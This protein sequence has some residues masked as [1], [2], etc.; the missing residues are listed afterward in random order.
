MGKK[1]DPGV[2]RQLRAAVTA[3]VAKKAGDPVVLDVRKLAD[4]CDYFFI[5][6]GSNPHQ[7]QA[8]AEAVE[9]RVERS[10]GVRPSHREGEREGEWIV[11]DYLDFIIHVF[12]PR[13]RRF[14][15]LERLWGGAP[16]LELPAA[17]RKA[18]TL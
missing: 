15:D 12:S 4:F 6:E 1:T 17:A 18:A 8:I 13:I 11:L 9:L 14:Y 16:R 10:G 3:A 7:I 2:R 5:C